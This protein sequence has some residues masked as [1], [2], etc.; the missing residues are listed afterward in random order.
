MGRGYTLKSFGTALGNCIE[1]NADLLN[2]D[3][4]TCTMVDK[5]L[6]NFSVIVTCSVMKWCQPAIAQFVHICRVVL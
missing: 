1:L 3:L 2:A 4:L 6:Y 5:Q